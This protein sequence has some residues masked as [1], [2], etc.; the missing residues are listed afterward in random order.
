MSRKDRW[1]RN[2]QHSDNDTQQGS[3]QNQ[4]QFL[5]DEET[6][7]SPRLGS[8]LVTTM[9]RPRT[10][11]N[12]F[13][14]SPASQAESAPYD[15]PYERSSRDYK[16]FRPRSTRLKQ[17]LLDCLEE[18]EDWYPEDKTQNWDQEMDWRHEAQVLIPQMDTGMQWA[19][20]HE[21]PDPGRIVANM[22]TKRKASE[23]QMNVVME[24]QDCD[25]GSQNPPGSGSSSSE[26][27]DVE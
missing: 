25:L 8:Y 16:S 2:Y 5:N 20:G 9:Q 10:S 19:W 4:H 27:E 15:H 14:Q 13:L 21:R 3:N 1:R 18:L 24:T 22:G 6:R 26:S 7:E 11:P 12:P 23:G 17:L